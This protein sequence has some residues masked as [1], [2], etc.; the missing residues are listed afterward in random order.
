LVQVNHAVAVGPRNS[1]GEIPVLADDGA[2]ASLRTLRGGIVIRPT[3]FNPERIILDDVL[4]ATPMAKVGDHF[5]T[6]VGVM[7]YSFG[8]FKLLV[9]ATPALTDGGLMR[10]TTRAPADY[11]IA[12]VTYNVENVEP[13]SVL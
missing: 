3:D 5:S 9:T 10:E 11:E 12:A 4:A 2:G 8:N 7:D 6:V 1:F 13:A